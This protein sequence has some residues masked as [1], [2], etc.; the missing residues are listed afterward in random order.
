MDLLARTIEVFKTNMSSWEEAK[1]LTDL[2][3]LRFP[4][5]SVN[6]D[7][8]D[9]DKILRVVSPNTQD[10][11]ELQKFIENRGIEIERLPD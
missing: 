3:A 5:V 10:V 7:L 9:C 8:E 2:L 11:E 6:F 1:K 4:H